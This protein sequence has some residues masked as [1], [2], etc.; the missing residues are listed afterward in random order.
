MPS[1]IG[2][3]R[4]AGYEHG[5]EALLTLARVLLDNDVQVITDLT[6]LTRDDLEGTEVLQ[7]F[8]LDFVDKVGA[9]LYHD[10][11]WANALGSLDHPQQ[12]VSISSD[13]AIVSSAVKRLS[14]SVSTDASGM[15]PMAVIRKL[16]G[17]ALSDT[18]R[19]VWY[20]SAR[21]AAI[22]GSCPKSHKSAMSG[23]RCYVAFGEAVGAGL[24]PSTDDLLAWSQLFRS[25]GTFMNYVGYVKFACDLMELPC[26]HLDQRLLAR[27]KSSIDKRRQFVPRGQYFLRLDMVCMLLRLAEGVPPLLPY[28]MAFLT[29]YVFLLR[30]PSECL[31][32]RTDGVG[33][34]ADEQAVIEVTGEKIS[35]KL[36]TR[37]NKLHGSLLVR[38]C[39]CK[40]CLET[41]P[42]HVLGAYYKDLGEGVKPF[43]HITAASAL[44]V[45]R[46]MLG[47]LEVERAGLY[48]THDFRRGHARDMQACGRTLAEILQAGEWSSP[49]FM[50]YLDMMALERDAVMEAHLDESGDEDA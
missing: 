25:S 38:R 1:L 10:T 44:R 35:L 24:P 43:K 47:Q 36:R 27:A 9:R 30:L 40:S 41:C 3:M 48:R 33:E 32:I 34:S 28:A 2:Q 23:L 12:V 18:E 6:R 15:G 49:A 22:S 20:K 37:K 21:T 13:S 46:D 31:P 7:D 8:D 45:L 14:M 4:A 29:S 11:M 39:W 16:N 19:A 50:K 5:E 17:S 26:A 42:V